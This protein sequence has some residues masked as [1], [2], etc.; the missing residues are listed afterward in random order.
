MSDTISLQNLKN[1][2]SLVF[3]AHFYQEILPHHCVHFGFKKIQ[4]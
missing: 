2:T 1:G 4:M 3:F